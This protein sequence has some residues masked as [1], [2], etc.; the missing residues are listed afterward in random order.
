[1]NGI[2]DRCPGNIIK[3][4]PEFK[5]SALSNLDWPPQDLIVLIDIQEGI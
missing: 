5:G 4:L 2:C 3:K 1:M